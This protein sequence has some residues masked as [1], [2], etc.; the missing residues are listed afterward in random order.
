MRENLKDPH[1]VPQFQLEK[2]ILVE[3][4]PTC[5][6][7]QRLQLTHPDATRLGLVPGVTLGGGG[8]APPIL[9]VATSGSVVGISRETAR[10]GIRNRIG[11][12]LE[13]RPIPQKE[14][15]LILQ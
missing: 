13:T 8:P 2:V 1:Q 5:L 3:V 12:E 11:E 7:V 6:G 4:T 15:S 9:K 14:Q 10:E